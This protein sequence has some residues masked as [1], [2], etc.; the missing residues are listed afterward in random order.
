MIKPLLCG[1]MIRLRQIA[2]VARE[3]DTAVEQIRHHLDVDVCY[4]DP[5]VGE[6]GLH[7]ALFRIGDQ[8]LE[9]VSP[10]RSDTTAGR[11]LEKAGADCGYM[12]IFE[13]DDLD[14]RMDLVSRFGVRVVWSGDFRQIRG[15]HLHPKDTGGTLV[16][17]DQPDQPGAWHWAGPRWRDTRPAGVAKGIVDFTI[18]TP[19]PQR[20]QARWQEL[21]INHQVRFL[22]STTPTEVLSGVSLETSNSADI[23]R[24]F[25]LCGVDFTL[26]SPPNDPT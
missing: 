8:F 11:L 9:V 18:S 19:Q 20:C 2:L 23:G 13:V 25:R 5:G 4:R 15:R 16:S 10:I 26:T 24:S 7:N 1:G 21:G 17:L 22:G 14:A 6:F 3:L 12:A